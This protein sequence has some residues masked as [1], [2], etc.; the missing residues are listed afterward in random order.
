VVDTITI[1]DLDRQLAQCLGVDGRASFSQL[2]EV[3]GVSDQTVARRY[4]RLRSAG[5]LRVVGLKARKQLGSLGWFLRIRCVPGAGPAIAAALARRADT[6]WI[7][8][9]SGNTEVLCTLRGDAREDREALLAKLPRGERIVDVTAHSLLHMFTGG[10]DA[11][12]FLQVLPASRVEPLQQP[13]RASHAASQAGSHVELGEL[14]FALFD[15]LGVDG[16]AS[17]AELAAATGWSESTVRRRMDQLRAVGVLYFDVE[18]DMPAFGFQS[19]TWLW[20]S[21]PPA[22]LAAA[23]AALAKFPEVAYA[24]ATTGAANLAACVV[25][26]DETEFYEFLTAKAATLPG[27]QRVETAPIIRTMK[28]AS[29]ARSLIAAGAR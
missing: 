11:L 15:A 4:R 19:A 20:L 28:Q 16:R 22:D 21:V 14:D 2:A 6:A 9:L 29:P 24:A 12:G 23:G 1:D 17:H 27:V 10:P 7:Q 26:R 18:L 25:C 8:L 5:V 3:L 13:A